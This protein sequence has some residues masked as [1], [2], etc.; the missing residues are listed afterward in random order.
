MMLFSKHWVLI[1]Y[2]S[3]LSLYLL[4]PFDDDFNGVR[5]VT[6]KAQGESIFTTSEQL[7]IFYKKTN[8][9]SFFK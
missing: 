6:P 1:T 4:I 9:Y 7:T 5:D 2:K 8:R 3:S